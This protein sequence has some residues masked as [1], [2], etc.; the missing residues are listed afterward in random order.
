[1]ARA[2]LPPSLRRFVELTL[3]R[4]KKNLPRLLSTASCALAV[5]A[6]SAPAVGREVPAKPCNYQD[7][8]P[9]YEKFAASTAGLVP[10]QRAVAFVSDFAAQY[11]DYYAPEVFGDAARMQ[12]RA[13]RYF[14]PA[15]AAA[16][17]PGVPPL[18]A[19]RLAALGRVVGPQFARQQRRFMQTFAD[20]TCDTT[21]EFGV[22]L[23]KF[24]GHPADFG[25]KH[26]LLFGVDI[27]AMLHEPAD[28]PAFFDHEI[29]HLYHRQVIGARA[30]QDDEPAWWTMWTEGLATY[31]SQRMNPRLDAQQVL[32]YPRDMVTRME[33]DRARAARFMLR[34]IDKTGPDAD[35]WFLASDSVEGL[36]IRAGYYLGYLFAKSQGDGRPLPE[37]ARMSPELVHGAA[38]TF[39]TQ[40]AETGGSDRRRTR[41]GSS[42]QWWR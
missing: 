12:A 17:F 40:L 27:I 8:M 41:S 5:L 23:M 19:G 18:T 39:L 35:R 10:Q 13:L 20:F 25:G 34:D 14:D 22:S 9:A 31:V 4:L 11:R 38:V 1:M 26:Y 21:V 37:L 36:P 16:I 42:R 24:D 28:M 3:R 29:F 32:W 33:Q 6:S 7:L 2:Y 30:P 15:Q